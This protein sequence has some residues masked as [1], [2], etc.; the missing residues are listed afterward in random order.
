MSTHE[1]FCKGSY[2]TMLRGSSAALFDSGAPV[3]KLM[4]LPLS[5]PSSSLFTRLS[6][7]SSKV[8]RF[9]HHNL[10]KFFS[11]SAFSVSP[12]PVLPHC[13]EEAEWRNVSIFKSEGNGVQPALFFFHL[14]MASFF[15]LAMQ[16]SFNK[17]ESFSTGDCWSV[18][19]VIAM[20]EITE[21]SQRSEATKFSRAR[22][23]K[24]CRRGWT[25]SYVVKEE[26]SKSP[27]T[28]KFPG[29]NGA[30]TTKFVWCT[31]KVVQKVGS[32]G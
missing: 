28:P 30:D 29:K 20:R 11:F 5:E 3:A 19:W 6:C 27:K 1:N 8:S 31:R 4:M 18:S 15:F 9:R 10:A 14:L 16:Y 32:Y 22:M 21:G 17:K 23:P 24:Q 2:H 7:L 13:S 12:L 26:N 25:A